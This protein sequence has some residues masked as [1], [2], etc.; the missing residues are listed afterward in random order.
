MRPQLQT[1]LLNT[2]RSEA[3]ETLIREDIEVLDT[4]SGGIPTR[5][6]PR[7]PSGTS[8]K[9]GRGTASPSHGAVSL[10]AVHGVTFVNGRPAGIEGRRLGQSWIGLGEA[11]PAYRES[12]MMMAMSRRGFLAS[13]GDLGLGGLLFDAQCVSTEGRAAD[14]PRERSRERTTMSMVLETVF[15]EGLAHLSYLIG[16]KRTGC[17]AVID[18]R[19]DVEVYVDLAR[20]HKL[21]I[22]H[23]LE[24]HIHADFVSGSRELADR[25]GSAK[26]LVSAEGGARYGFPHQELRDGDRIDLG[27][28]ILM[29]RHTPGHTPEH[30]SYLAAEGN[31][32]DTP[33]AVF[34]GD[35]LFADS[36]GRPDL[37]GEDKSVGLA[38][39]LFRSV[40]EFYLKLPDDV[41]VHPAHGAGS[42]CGA[43]I[44]DR[45]VT[46][47]GYE[48]RFNPALQIEDEAKFVEYVLSTAPPEPRYYPRMKEINARGPEVLGR[49][50]TA[51]ALPP[52]AF[53]RAVEK[54]DVHLVDNRQMLAFGGGHIAGALNIGPRA[55]LS[56]WAG[57]ML[58]PDKPIFLVLPKDGD[59]PEVLRQF[60]RV[61]YT[62]FGGYLLGGMEEWVNA[63]LPLVTLP[64]LTVQELKA[65]PA[66]GRVTDT[67]RAHAFGVGGRPRPGGAVHLPARTG[68]EARPARQG[69]AGGGV[70]RQR[71]PRQPRGE[72][73]P[74]ERLRPRPQRAGELEGVD[75]GGLPRREA[76]GA[77]EGVG[78]GS[79]R[80][81]QWQR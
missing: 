64:Q 52:K 79:V 37:L 78:H 81:H 15:T 71:L 1:A 55:E 35:C 63:G 11:P 22:T 21:A 62:R 50:P 25:T 3:V 47:I 41:R 23:V 53:Q 66:P 12:N 61:G 65:L 34:S 67:R 46:T 68:E 59:L 13:I 20:R 32:P 6:T 28:V 51:P 29:A 42:P 36:V 70:L 16:D 60:L 27:R 44:S 39:E 17:A 40:R 33:F 26:I 58:D 72:H 38:K 56:I 49:L 18:P 4:S 77:Q 48:R 31:R 19:R 43:N 73:P 14:T 5:M 76:Q 80:N 7:C 9:T 74:A 2:P 57:W 45:L 54:D 24:T 30:L 10:D 69:Q 75:G 8:R